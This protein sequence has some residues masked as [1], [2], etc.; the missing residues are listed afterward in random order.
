MKFT[1]LSLKKFSRKL[2]AMD[3]AFIENI[4]HNYAC[5]RLSIQDQRALVICDAEEASIQVLVQWYEM[6]NIRR[7]KTFYFVDWS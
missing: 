4:A 1:R 7:Q 5:I 3:K 6:N 2:D